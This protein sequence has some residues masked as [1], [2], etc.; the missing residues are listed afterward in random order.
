MRFAEFTSLLYAGFVVQA[1][2]YAPVFVSCGIF[3]MI[4]SGLALYLTKNKGLG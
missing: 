3:F 4:F 1:V 2:G